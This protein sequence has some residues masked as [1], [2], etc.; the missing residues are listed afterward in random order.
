MNDIN[1]KN[2]DS[3]DR[4][5]HSTVVRGLDQVTTKREKRKV[6]KDL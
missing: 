4:F 3:E 5:C 2:S 1:I 6:I